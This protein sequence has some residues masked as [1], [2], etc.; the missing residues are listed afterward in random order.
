MQ[1]NNE[2]FFSTFLCN[3]NSPIVLFFHLLPAAAL[4]KACEQT[5]N[6]RAVRRCRFLLSV[7]QKDLK[8]QRRCCSSCSSGSFASLEK[9]RTS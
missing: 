2:G 8:L 4:L 3:L 7:L 5:Q 9:R 1:P 6:E